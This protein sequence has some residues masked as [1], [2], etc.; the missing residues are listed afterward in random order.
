MTAASGVATKDL[1]TRSGR[2][3]GG[4]DKTML[5][6]PFSTEIARSRIDDWHREAHR[7]RLATAATG[8]RDGHGSRPHGTHLRRLAVVVAALFA[9]VAGGSAAFAMPMRAGGQGSHS[10]NEVARYLPAS[11]GL[12]GRVRQTIPLVHRHSARVD[13]D[14]HSPVSRIGEPVTVGSEPRFSAAA[15]IPAIAVGLLTLGLLSMSGVV[16]AH[17]RTAVT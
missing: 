4:K 5:Y 15:W 3:P 17:R 13:V 10:S 9:L 1:L 6:S 16:V 8:G 12:E 2:L 7:Y 11:R 14:R